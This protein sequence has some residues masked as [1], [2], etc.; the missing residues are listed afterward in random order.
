MKIIVSYFGNRLIPRLVATVLHQSWSLIQLVEG[1]MNPTFRLI[2][3]EVSDSFAGWLKTSHAT[4]TCIILAIS[5][6]YA[7]MA[8]YLKV[9]HGIS[10][11]VDAA[12]AIPPLIAVMVAFLQMGMRIKEMDDPN[13]KPFYFHHQVVGQALLM[14]VVVSSNNSIM[15]LFFVSAIAVSMYISLRTIVYNSV[16][17]ILSRVATELEIKEFLEVG[18]GL[19]PN[20][21]MRNIF[22]MS[23]EGDVIT[24]RTLLRLQEPA[25]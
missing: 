25:V 20:N 24:I 14:T 15:G 18:R 2:S 4:R 11:I 19:Y 10:D 8:T 21:V 5:V 1:E 12:L 22:D 9:F 3:R 13:P 23:L 16:S 17:D 7:A 6:L